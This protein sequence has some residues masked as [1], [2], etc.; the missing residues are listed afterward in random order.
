M[1]FLKNISIRHKQTLIILMT[2]TA[3]LLLAC[4]AFVVHDVLTFRQDM[5]QN[6]AGQAEMISDHAATCVQFGYQEET[7]SVLAI[8]RTHRNI[9][10]AWI[11][12]SD[13]A[14][15]AEFTKSGIPGPRDHTRRYS[16]FGYSFLDGALL[17]SRPIYFQGERIGAIYIESNLESM[18]ARLRN[19]AGIVLTVLIVSFVVA[20]IMSSRLQSLI[21]QPILDLAETTRAV[22]Q[23]KNYSVRVARQ[24]NDEIGQLIDGFNEMLTQVHERDLALQQA[25]ANLEKRVLE[26]TKELQLEISERRRAEEALWESEQQYAQIAL[27][28]SDVLYV[29]HAQTQATDWYGQIDKALGYESG[30]FGRDVASL[31]KLIHAE[32]LPKLRD[33]RERSSKSGKAFDVEYRILHKNGSYRFWS[34]RG[35]PVYDQRGQLSKFIGACTDITERKHAEMTDHNHA[36]QE[37]VMAD[38]G[39]LALTRIDLQEL[40]DKAVGLVA[41][42]LRTEFGGILEFDSAHQQFLLRAGVGWPRGIVGQAQFSASESNQ[43]GFTLK[44]NEAVVVSDH[45]SETR[46]TR[47][48]LLRDQPVRSGISVVI[49]G[50]HWPFGVLCAD[51]LNPR[52]FE[53]DEIRFLQSVANL[54]ATAI[55][56]NQVEQ[57]LKKAKEDAE[58]ASEAKSQFLANMSHE[59]R[60]P[61]NGVL[62]MTNLALETELTYEQRGLLNTVKESADTLL[63]VINEILDFSKI[64]AGKLELLHAPFTFR[65]TLEDIILSLALRAQEKG[66]ELMCHIPSDI[67]R[68]L[69]GDSSRLRQILVNLIGNAIKFTLKGEIV[70]RIQCLGTSNGHAELH[71]SVQDT[72]IGIPTDKQSVIFESFTQADNSMTRSYGGTGLGLAISMR[73]VELM[74]GRIWVESQPGQGSTF[75]FNC[76]FRVEKEQLDKPDHHREAL[77]DLPILVVEDNA[78]H[79][80]ILGD[81]LA[82]WRMQPILAEDGPQALTLMEER[83]V[84]Q[85]PI[86]LVIIDSMMPRM[87]GFALARQIK[88]RPSWSKPIV[89]MLSSTGHLTDASRCRDLGIETYLSKPVKQSELLDAILGALGHTAQ[90]ARKLASLSQGGGRNTSRKL[91]I[92]LAEDHPVNQR[93]AIRLLEKWGHEVELA[94][95]GR[96]AV[97][98]YGR[99]Q[100]DLILMDIQMP[101][102]SG[103][104]ATKAIRESE[105]GTGQ[106]IPIIAMTAHAMKGDRERCLEIGMDH[107]IT[108]PLNPS[109]LF[110]MI[111]SCQDGGSPL[112]KPALPGELHAADDSSPV[113]LDIA[114]A[115]MDGD[116]ELLE[117]LLQIFLEDYPR[118]LDEIGSAIDRGDGKQ[119]ERAAHSLK[120]SVGNF[121]ARITMEKSL[122]LENMGRTGQLEQAPATFDALVRSIDQLIPALSELLPQ[123]AA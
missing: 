8:L 55:E 66:L 88:E 84:A 14:F 86:S 111:E 85:Q 99:G 17:V 12:T 97:E 101:E 104:E 95:N 21:S 59:I 38:L 116:K 91:R 5:I 113:D 78:T 18:Y 72:G 110:E 24:S 69:I 114:L 43:A 19:Y 15:L 96:K 83:A 89:M 44:G 115:R 45:D 46:F 52:V 7:K 105:T 67:P 29:T 60:T 120:G 109:A 93:L 36:L 117:E 40:I 53:T 56:R 35:R 122:Q 16:T 32:D 33:A 71:F 42:T 108:K 107:Y 94:P 41:Q 68:T 100:S 6:L 48:P 76:Q 65:E 49:H 54:L 13:G 34:D 118:L 4:S 9:T 62:G 73:L 61:M 74:G 22:A 77:A 70:V 20:V 2:S 28:A 39:Q 102:M 80:Q 51:S 63:A 31:E 25:H 10:G 92:I 121:G 37:A 81:M 23:K 3:A 82:N 26:R 98:A 11:Y 123:K 64:E 57:D 106:H 75:H 50:R 103:F 47:I 90:G 79:R 112:Q 119:L 87:D 1:N 27:N 58:A 30:E